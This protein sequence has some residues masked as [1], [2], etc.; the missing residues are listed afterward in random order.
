M[1]RFAL[2][3]LLALV[4]AASAATFN[5]N[6]F[7]LAC[8]EVK[9]PSAKKAVVDKAVA[10]L[11]TSGKINAIYQKWFQKPVPPKN[12][13]LNLPASPALNVVPEPVSLSLLAIGVTS[14]LARRRR[15]R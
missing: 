12:V 3:L 8:I 15:S 5:G 6:E 9:S 2:S 10:N 13:N 4:S 7:A 1:L 14:L 11:Y